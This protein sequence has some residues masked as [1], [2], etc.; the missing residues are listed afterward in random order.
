[1]K[2]KELFYMLGALGSERNDFDD[3]KVVDGKG[4]GVTGIVVDHDKKEVIMRQRNTR[5]EHRTD[6]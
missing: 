2:A 5:I 4:F 1:M 3:Y 6:L